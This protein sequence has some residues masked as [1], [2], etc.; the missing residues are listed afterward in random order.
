MRVNEFG[1]PVGETLD[2]APRIALAPVTLTGRTCRLEPV[3]EQHVD[4]LY[5]ALCVDS[6]PDIWTYMPHGPFADRDELAAYAG[7]LNALPACASSARRR[8]SVAL[9]PS[10]RACVVANALPR[11]GS[12]TSGSGGNR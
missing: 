5:A 10:L 2:W 3:G 1:Q 11:M 8:D 12:G 6:P 9:P 7:R 4:G